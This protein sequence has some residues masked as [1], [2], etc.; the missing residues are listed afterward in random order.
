LVGGDCTCGRTHAR[1]ARF[2]GRVDDMLVVRGINVFPSEIEAVVLEHPALAGQYAI[3]VD[4]RPTLPELEV[5]VE[6]DG[7]VE[8][9]EGRLERRLRLR[10][11]VVTHPTGSL[12]R[13][14]TGKAKRLFERADDTDPW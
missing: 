14:E 8:G 6:A 12:P 4:R 13:T 3:V 10:C 7:P 1:I 5:H 2:S 9:L 11:A